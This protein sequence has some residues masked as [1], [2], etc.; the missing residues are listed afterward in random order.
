MS[1][2]DKDGHDG[3]A[4]D[5]ELQTLK[6]KPCPPHLPPPPPPKKKNCRVAGPRVTAGCGLDRDQHLRP[7]PRRP[8]Q[9][10]HGGLAAFN[11]PN[12]RIREDLE[13]FRD[14]SVELRQLFLKGGPSRSLYMV[15]YLLEAV[16][17]YGPLALN[18]KHCT[19]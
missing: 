14:A 11:A 4:V 2:I 1:E 9:L 5:A 7:S 6:P 16:L 10:C 8:W 3:R 18:P 17:K 13:D 12:H 15:A 19:G